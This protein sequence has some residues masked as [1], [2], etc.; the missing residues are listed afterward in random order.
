MKNAPLGPSG[1]GQGNESD[2]ESAMR[3]IEEANEAIKA[4]LQEKMRERLTGVVGFIGSL[5]RPIGLLDDEVREGRRAWAFPSPFLDPL[6]RRN[7]VSPFPVLSHLQQ[8]FL[9]TWEHG[10]TVRMD[11]LGGTFIYANVFGPR[12]VKE[13]SKRLR[14]AFGRF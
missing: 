4:P 12:L 2:V 1:S 14:V 8:Y 9:G 3:T 6:Y 5:P 7:I 10:V 11:Y 13:V